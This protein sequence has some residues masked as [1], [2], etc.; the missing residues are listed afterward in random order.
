MCAHV[1]PLDIPPELMGSDSDLTAPFPWFGGKRR[2]ARAVWAA[3][4]DV[5]N[6]VEPFAGS[7]AV[8]LGRPDSH[9]GTT[10][11]VN[12]KDSFICNFWRALIADP[13]AVAHHADWPVVETDKFARHMWL[14]Q[15]G[16]PK[17]LAGL[18]ADPDYY[19]AK[20]AGWWVWGISLWIGSGWCSGK[21]PWSV[22]EGTAAKHGDN[23]TGVSRQRP[24]LSSAGQG[25][26]RQLPHL[27]DPGRGVNRQ[28]A[29]DL[30]GYFE[31]L[32]ERLRHVRVCNGDWARV[33]S[34][35][36][37][38][39]G[40]TVGVFLD[41]PYL[42]SVRAKD[43]YAVDD[44][45]ISTAVAEW[46]IANGDD[47]RLRIVLAGYRPEHDEMV[48]PSWQR[49]TWSAGASFQTHASAERADGNAKN[50]GLECLWLSPH[51]NRVGLDDLI[52]LDTSDT[53]V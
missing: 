10:E 4:G 42:G 23:G 17:M 33:T 18:E 5:D 6:Y 36:A 11:T 39:Y 16:Q 51:C 44:H 27:G 32:A 38:N 19:D 13:E 45:S 40:S 21:G 43:L 7:L 26:S 48:P 12:D 25:V 29:D 30:I 46:A 8:L 37:L 3:L 20:I 52:P 53:V 31:H 15:E 47:P 14:V 34:P 2:V 35:G 28:G 24:H 50:R 22:N 41:P 9:T 1:R 49:L